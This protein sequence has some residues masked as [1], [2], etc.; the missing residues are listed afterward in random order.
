MF[1]CAIILLICLLNNIYCQRVKQFD[2]NDRGFDDI[3]TPEPIENEPERVTN[4]PQ[5]IYNNGQPC[6]CVPYYQC[7]ISNAVRTTDNRINKYGEVNIRYDTHSCQDVLDVCCQESEILSGTPISQKQPQQQSQTNTADG[8]CGIRKVGG[9]DFTI[10]GNTN[11]EAGFGEFPWTVALLKNVQGHPVFICAG[12]LIHPSVILTGA[13]CVQ[14]YTASDLF[15]RA[16]EWDT[17]TTKERLPHQQRPVS[18]VAIHP[19]FNPRSLANDI[20]LLKLTNPVQLDEHINVVCLP[21]Q[22]YYSNSGECFAT[23][24]GKNVFGKKGKY[25]VIM[26][27]VPLPM[28]EFETCQDALRKT[29]LTKHFRLHNSFVC[30]GGVQGTD[31]CQGDGGAPLVCPSSSGVPN[32]YVQIGTVAWGIGCNDAI[33]GVYSNV[34]LFRQW[35]DD[36]VYEFGY[37]PSVYSS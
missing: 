35:I 16:G 4:E 25:S 2:I 33:P 23:G 22:N 5:I 8:G 28:V 31:T 20:A 36:T 15:V 9:I 26:K 6:R 30:A 18:E 1:K 17:Q 37:D 32:K 13:H 10:T 3:V 21:Q 27:R 19:E 34:A 7:E 24:W 14:N 29:R 11:N 12:S